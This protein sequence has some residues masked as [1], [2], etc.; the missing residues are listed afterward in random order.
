[1]K[2]VSAIFWS[3]L[4]L[5]F[6]LLCSLI[7][8]LCL[9]KRLC[10]ATCLHCHQTEQGHL[11]CGSFCLEVSPLT[12]V[13]VHGTCLALFINCLRLS[14]LAVSGPEASLNRHCKGVPNKFHTCIDIDKLKIVINLIVSALFISRHCLLLTVQTLISS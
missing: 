10:G 6:A 4:N 3:S 2:R 14:S 12:C 1:M 7:S 8:Q 5:N 11:D 13:L 9:Q